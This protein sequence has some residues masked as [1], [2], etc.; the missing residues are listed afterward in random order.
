MSLHHTAT[1]ATTA[2]CRRIRVKSNVILGDCA[3][4]AGSDDVAV[5]GDG[6]ETEVLSRSLLFWKIAGGFRGGAVH[7]SF[8]IDVGSQGKGRRRLGVHTRVTG[9]L[10]VFRS[11]EKGGKRRWEW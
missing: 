6:R 11:L 5:I 9:P 1:A 8:I 4:K 3:L 2:G 7:T 10:L